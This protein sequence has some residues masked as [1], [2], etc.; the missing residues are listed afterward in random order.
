MQQIVQEFNLKLCTC[1]PICI[2]TCLKPVFQVDK[3]SSTKFHFWKLTD[4]HK[5]FFN[6]SIIVS[7][8]LHC[9]LFVCASIRA[10]HSVSEQY[11]KGNCKIHILNDFEQMTFKSIDGCLI[12]IWF[13]NFKESERSFKFIFCDCI[14][15]LEHFPKFPNF[16][17]CLGF[18]VLLCLVCCS[19]VDV[20]KWLYVACYSYMHEGNSSCLISIK[21]FQHVSHYHLLDVWSYPNSEFVKIMLKFEGKIFWW[22]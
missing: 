16:G 11:F 14:Y 1:L 20:L 13:D 19:Q 6:A 5:V 10:H 9:C 17:I 2:V 15:L 21:S 18:F 7:S 8:F 12:Q 3:A 4:S 22:L